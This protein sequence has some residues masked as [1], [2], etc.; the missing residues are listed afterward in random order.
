MRRSEQKS[1]SVQVVGAAAV[2]LA[3]SSVVARAAELGVLAPLLVNGA[4]QTSPDANGQPAPVLERVREGELYDALQREAAHGFTGAMLALDEAAQR[5]AG[6]VSP[7][8]TWLYLSLEDGGFA[9]RGF[10]LSENGAER[11]VDEPFLDIVVDM[12]SI[13]DG[14]FEELFAHEMGHVF[15]RRLLPKL[16]AGYSRT[17]HSSLAITDYPT[18]FDEGFAIH[19]QGLARRL[20]GNMRLREQELGLASKPFLSYWASHLDRATRIEGMRRNWF[21]QAQLAPGAAQFDF[22]RLKNPNQMLASE[23]VVATLFYRWWVPGP[24]DRQSLLDRYGRTFM[25]LRKLNERELEPDAPIFLDFVDAY[26]AQ[27]PSE[28]DA[29]LDLIVD[30]TYGATMDGATARATEA[31]A[32]RGVQGDMRGF[33]GELAPAREALADARARAR[34]SPAALRAGLAPNLWLLCPSEPGPQL[35]VNLNTA[36][37]EELLRTPGLDRASAERAL[38]SRRS[39]GLFADLKDFVARSGVDAS[40]AAALTSAMREAQRAGTYSRR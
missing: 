6:A 29:V 25:A 11:Y 30:A 36:E 23:G 38:S 15:L 27:F 5:T 24:G 13:A 39:A 40:S 19:F 4:P 22:T 37:L 7:R 17:P 10:W 1:H 2:L 21:V 35:T 20:T 33:V 32:A 14:A 31:L 18:A 12:G 28:R 8:P 3:M 34:R 16:P 9:R 26:G